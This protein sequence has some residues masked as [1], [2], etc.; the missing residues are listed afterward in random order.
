MTD[1]KKEFWNELADS[2]F[3]M[4]GLTNESQ[5]AIPMTAQLDPD[6]DSCFWFYTTKDNRVAKGGPAMA[7][8]ISKGQDI[9]A[10]IKGTLN[11]ETD[12]AVIDRYWSKPVAAWYEGGRQ[13][14]N[15]LMLRFDLDD[16]EIWHS[17]PSLKGMFK[18]MTGKTIDKKSS[19][20]GE[21]AHVS[22]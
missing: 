8:F 11:E 22:L 3:V 17:D 21:H 5:H 19:E 18:L 1:I 14:P 7:Q 20:M 4:L 13:D 6:A 12:E 15:L 9:F 2:R 10:C 16:A